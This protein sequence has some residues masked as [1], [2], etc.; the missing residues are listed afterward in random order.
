MKD[1]SQFQDFY[2]RNLQQ[3]GASAQGVG[4]KNEEAQL[5]R[6]LKLYA[7]ISESRCTSFS[8]NDLGCGVGD[9]VHFLSQYPAP[10]HY[11]GYD[12]ML[13]MIEKA[14]TIHKDL[15]HAS[16]QSIHKASEMQVSDFTIASGIFNIRFETT[17]EAWLNYI[18]ET[19]EVM[20][21]KSRKGFAFNVLSTYSDIEYRKNELYYADPEYLFSYCKKSFSKNVALLHDY[22]QYDFT[23][24]V[25]K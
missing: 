14:K 2:Q 17:D 4:W 24:I 11:L 9:F 12:V 13:E 15:A 19:L 16:F 6:F 20:N 7:L 21:E 10:F 3:F 23:L 18:L 1:I 25:R 22:D 5:V 8:L